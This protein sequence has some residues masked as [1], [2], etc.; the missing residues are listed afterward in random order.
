MKQYLRQLPHDKLKINQNK[1]PIPMELFLSFL[2][3]DVVR[4]KEHLGSCN[5][6][7]L[8]TGEN[9]LQISGGV[10]NGV[11]Y[12]DSLR[13]KKKLDND[14]N[15]YINPF[16]MFDILNDEGKQFFFYYYADDIDAMLDKAQKASKSAQLKAIAAKEQEQQM[17]VF[18]NETMQ[19]I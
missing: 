1:K 3:V 17:S 11:E 8:F 4:S 10:V 2:T 13:Y 19:I 5:G 9:N 7:T 16:Y 14:Y 15:D 12:I 18:W 6:W